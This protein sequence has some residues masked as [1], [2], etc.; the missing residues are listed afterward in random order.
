MFIVCSLDGSYDA[1]FSQASLLH[2]PKNEIR[3]VLSGFVEKLNSGG[4]LYIAV[5]E[6][7]PDKPD[8]SVV[9]ENDYG[10]SY[11]RFFSFFTMDELRDH[12]ESLGMEIVLKR[13]EKTGRSTWLQIIGKK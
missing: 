1:I 8:E 9:E 13:A 12:L 2:I 3:A 7:W 4:L 6:A 10:Y 11:K 5:K